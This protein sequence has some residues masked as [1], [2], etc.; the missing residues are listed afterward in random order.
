M[1][2]RNTM[3]AHRAVVIAFM[4]GADIEVS[5]DGKHWY[6]TGNP[7]WDH[8]LLFREKPKVTHASDLVP[9]DVF[10]L[11]YQGMNLYMIDSDRNAVCIKSSILR[12]PC[13]FG[14]VDEFCGAA[15]LIRVKT[16]G[17]HGAVINWVQ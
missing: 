15:T 4:D 2:D 11:E 8:D 12:V 6:D 3:Q 14:N 1:A 10:Y 5:T 17:K 16:D 9:G 7:S 13:M